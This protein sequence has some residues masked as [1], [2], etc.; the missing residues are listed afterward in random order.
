VLHSLAWRDVSTVT[1]AVRVWA[2]EGADLSLPSSRDASPQRAKWTNMKE[3]TINSFLPCFD[4]GRVLWIGNPHV[5]FGAS[6][7][8]S[9]SNKAPE[10]SA[11][12]HSIQWFLKTHQGCGRTLGARPCSMGE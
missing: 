12:L 2:S 11:N 3:E 7:F 8:G 10:D 5:A 9:D 6:S 4:N 1:G